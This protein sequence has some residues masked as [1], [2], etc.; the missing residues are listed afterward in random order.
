M[1]KEL[2][3]MIN[4]SQGSV[5]K[6]E[7]IKRF[8]DKLKTM[9]YTYIMLYTEDTYE[10]KEEPYFGYL[11]G[12]YSQNEIKEIVDYCEKLNIEVI[13]CIQTLG[14]LARLLRN[15]AFKG[16]MNAEDTLYVGE[17]KTYE[18]IEK[19]I[20][21]CAEQF[22]SRR[23]N[24]GMDES[25]TMFLGR[26]LKEKGLKDKY[27]VLIY[28]VKRVAEIA[29]KYGFTPYMWSDMFF[30][31]ARGNYYAVTDDVPERVVSAFKNCG[32]NFIYWD[33]FEDG[34]IY[35][36]MINQHKR[37]G[38]DI[39]FAGAA[40]NWIGF[41]TSNFHSLNKTK[42][43]IDSCERAGVKNYL[44]TLW[45][46]DLCSDYAVL[47]TLFFTAEYARGNRDMSDIKNKFE[48][49]FGE[50]WDDFLLFDL[51]LP[52]EIKITDDITAGGIQYFAADPF[53]SR[54]DS[55]V[56]E[57]GEEA[58]VYSDYADKFCKAAERSKNYKE[59]FER[60]AA[61][62]RVLS[63][64]YNLGVDTRKAYKN[65]DKSALKKVVGDYEKTISAMRDFIGIFR[66][67]FFSEMKGHGYCVY[68]MRWGGI[69]SR[70]ITCRDRL[71]DYI[72]GRIDKIEEL[73][74]EI[75]DYYGGNACEKRVPGEF[76]DFNKLVTVYTL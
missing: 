12:R 76:Q 8:A 34:T 57:N 9:G 18:L 23:I 55:T 72:D 25:D 44:Q 64:K 7:S 42:M 27:E 69:L 60:H 1:I 31:F 32:M 63:L 49:T 10:I 19:M 47:P 51:L 26:F 66:T 37:F 59:I 29:A 6:V 61:Y 2:G 62:A 22:R 38:C 70:L 20:K 48:K 5:K 68:D 65:A 30:K 15:P 43:A 33:Y 16:V 28:H 52:E 46:G 53:L 71:V 36:S 39:W 41:A 4:C 67:A 75:L 14:H 54:F 40:C 74:T 56:T 24:V 45:G 21:A 11:R 35:D 3:V 50:R 73:E 13:P 17:E 58:K